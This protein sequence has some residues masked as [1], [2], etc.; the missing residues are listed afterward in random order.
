MARLSCTVDSDEPPQLRMQL[1]NPSCCSP[2][3]R[4]ETLL[5]SPR[6]DQLQALP[7]QIPISLPAH[8]FTTIYLVKAPPDIKSSGARWGK[9]EQAEQPACSS[10]RLQEFPTWTPPYLEAKCVQC[11]ASKLKGV[12][13]CKDLRGKD[14]QV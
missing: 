12:D 6:K 9:Q 4:G 3:Q 13:L 7:S 1:P 2:N 11:H 10:T 14:H 5:S 8:K